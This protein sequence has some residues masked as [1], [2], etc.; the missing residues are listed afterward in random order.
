MET[1]GYFLA[2]KIITEQYMS[3]LR[4]HKSRF[5]YA[6]GNHE[7]SNAG[8]GEINLEFLLNGLLKRNYHNLNIDDLG[9]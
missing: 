2:A 6:S 5:D 4:E 1:G 7:P 9:T 8:T 3:V